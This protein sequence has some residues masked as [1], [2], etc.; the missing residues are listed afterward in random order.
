M[1]QTKTASQQIVEF[2]LT[3]KVSVFHFQFKNFF[4]FFVGG[5]Y[6]IP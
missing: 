2:V 6:K 5:T 1:F 3:N 4:I